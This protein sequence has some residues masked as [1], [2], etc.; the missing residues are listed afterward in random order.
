MR[1]NPARRRRACATG[2]A[3]LAMVKL[4]RFRGVCVRP[5]DHEPQED[6]PLPLTSLCCAVGMSSAVRLRLFGEIQPQVRGSRMRGASHEAAL[7][8]LTCQ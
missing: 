1:E 6:L 8:D 5:A 4:T 2:S 7:C 3:T